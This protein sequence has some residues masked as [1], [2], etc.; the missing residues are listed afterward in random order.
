[1]EY[2]DIVLESCT[3]DEELE[4]KLGF[5][6]IFK[7]NLSNNN[8]SHRIAYLNNPK[9][10]YLIKNHKIDA[11]IC[12]DYSLNKKFTE[13]IKRHKIILY[14]LIP[15]TKERF[16]LSKDLFKLQITFNYVIKNKIKAS[17]ISLASSP[18]YLCSYIQIIEFAKFI[19]ADEQYVRL[20]LNKFN[21]I[22]LTM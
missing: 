15:N 22:S 10:L 16:I 5:K 7:L 3:F 8:I 6:K 17:F 4:K 2:Y 21:N 13:L 12:N 20:C 14:F 11:V 1:M 9:I 18:K 19:G